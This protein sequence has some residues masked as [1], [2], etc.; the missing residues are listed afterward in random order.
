MRVWIKRIALGVVLLI[1]IAFA[2]VGVL[3]VTRGTPVEYV[4]AKDDPG[5]P[6]STDTPLFE[7]T[8][9]LNTGVAIQAG[10]A[11]QVL[12]NGDGTYPL[13]WRD[14]RSC[15]ST[16]TV[17]MYF[18]KPGIVADSLA[19]VLSACAKRKVRVLLLLDSFGSQSLTKE[20][21][22]R[23]QRDGVE[24]QW[25]RRLRW[26]ALHTAPERSHARVVVVDGRV[27]YTG[28]FGLA[29]Y[30]LGGGHA[31][32]E[33]R[34]TNVRFEGPAVAQLQAAFAVAWAEASGELLTG[35]RFY[36]PVAFDTMGTVHA[37]LFHAVPSTGSTPA[38]RFLA[39]TIAGARRTLYITN[40]YFVP[41]DDFRN[42][43]TRAAKRGVDVRV[44]TTG[45]KTD[46]QTTWMAGRWRYPELLRA[47]VRLY[48]YQPTNM[49]AKTI[50]VDGVWG[51]VGSMN[52][53]N[54]SLAFN[55]ETTLLVLDRRVVTGMD[56]MFVNDLKSSHE[57]TLAE[58]DRW[59]WWQRARSAVSDML[60]RV[61]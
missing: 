28:G 9:Q 36:P 13:L 60:E 6:P 44:L 59:P 49:H 54:R 16:V 58:V 22:L 3:T 7:Q 32:G 26:Y 2:M 53:D 33:W 37:G 52:F 34:E 24:V 12:Q 51:S 27:G 20:W 17:Q 45:E 10:N 25:L 42:M 30:W 38:E 19:A 43:L 8:I 50:S 40:A 31:V 48:E 55:N 29:D 23:L 46:V 61:L 18:A 14:I 1:L 41:D 39:L 35:E 57:V 56:S 4:I 47:G 15:G 21:V 11:V 5:G